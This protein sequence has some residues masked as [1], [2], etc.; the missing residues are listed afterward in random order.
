MT[1][2]DCS[3]APIKASLLSPLMI[4]RVTA[5]RTN[6]SL[7]LNDAMP[8]R[9]LQNQ[10]TL[11]CLY[12]QQPDCTTVKEEKTPQEMYDKLN[13]KSDSK[14]IA[15]FSEAQA[16]RAA[17]YHFEG[18]AKRRDKPQSDDDELL[19]DDTMMSRTHPERTVS[20]AERCEP[21]EF[22]IKETA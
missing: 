18:C 5:Y 3:C 9:T 7:T 11:K 10:Q 21:V 15:F 6:R 4:R 8:D 13:A 1:F 12:A 2:W 14:A 20:G 17:L 22:I 16:L 19:C